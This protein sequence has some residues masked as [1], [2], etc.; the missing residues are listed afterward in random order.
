MNLGKKIGFIAFII[1]VIHVI[2]GIIYITADGS[3]LY[4]DS[5][6]IYFRTGI[7]GLVL[8]GCSIGILKKNKEKGRTFAVISILI[9]LIFFFIMQFIVYC[10][11]AG[12]GWP[13]T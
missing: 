7:I 11:L 6:Q 3:Y 5:F 10:A 1:T 8:A 2:A 9:I 4:R 13:K 12:S